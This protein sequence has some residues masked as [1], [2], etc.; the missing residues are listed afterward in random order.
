MVHE[1]PKEMFKLLAKWSDNLLKKLVGKK[2]QC[3]L[4]LKG[5]Y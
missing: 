3:F 2:D 4:G 5:H 1:Q